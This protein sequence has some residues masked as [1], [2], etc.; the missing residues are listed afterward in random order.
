[1]V[2]PRKNTKKG[3][4]APKRKTN[5]TS[6]PTRSF[7]ARYSNK[8]SYIRQ[9]YLSF[10]QRRPHR[11]FKRTKRRDYS[12][13]LNLPGYIA[14][15]TE[16]V[17]LL[18]KQSKTIALMILVFTVSSALLANVLSQDT[19]LQISNLLQETS[20]NIFEGN[21]SEIGKAALLVA[22]IGGSNFS[23]DVSSSQQVFALIISV[24]IWLSTVWLLRAYMA[25]HKAKLR[26][27]LYSSGS[28]FIPSALLFVLLLIQ[29]IPGAV[30][31]IGISSAVSS[32]IFGTGILPFIVSIVALLLMVL[33]LYFITSTFFALIV[34]TLPGMYPWRALKIAGDLVVGRRLRI[35]YRLIWMAGVVAIGW[36]LIMVPVVLLTTLIQKGIGWLEVIPIVPVSLVAVSTMGLI[37]SSAYV[38]LLYRK[39]VDDDAAPA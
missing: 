1:M 5:S 11:S 6:K 37:F 28:P 7:K 14:F 30:A 26:D 12:R 29:L 16:T 9:L 38:Y 21:F 31:A 39:V 20:G 17:S 19:Y 2:K 33:S 24:F 18:R 36:V 34:I 13:S 25:G 10:L 32:S 22:S 3:A 8:A 15:T 35:L 27:A 4:A 23:T